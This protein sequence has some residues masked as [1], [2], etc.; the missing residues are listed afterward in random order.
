[1]QKPKETD[2]H[3]KKDQKTDDARQKNLRDFLLAAIVLMILC[4]IYAVRYANP[5]AAGEASATKTVKA[6]E[7]KLN[8]VVTV[9]LTHPNGDQLLKDVMALCDKYENIFSRTKEGSEIYKLNNGTLEK[10]GDTFILSPE[11]A[12]LVAKG[13]SLAVI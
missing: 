12:E 9:T 5:E 10:E 1:M 11:C 7:F 13:D 2:M 6:T 3:P 4:V 8:T